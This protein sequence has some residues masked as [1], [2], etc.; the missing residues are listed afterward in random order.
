MEV[1]ARNVAERVPLTRDSQLG[2]ISCGIQL[3]RPEPQEKV[4]YKKILNLLSKIAVDGPARIGAN[5]LS[6]LD[7]IDGQIFEYI[8]L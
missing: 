2:H 1:R 8:S 5:S 4:E 7:F 6:F 3:G